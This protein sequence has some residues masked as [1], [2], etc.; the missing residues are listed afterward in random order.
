DK[1][2]TDPEFTTRFQE[3]IPSGLTVA[4]PVGPDVGP[5]PW[6]IRHLLFRIRHLLFRTCSSDKKKLDES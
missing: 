3:A 6:R 5:V 2:V 4:V 1:E